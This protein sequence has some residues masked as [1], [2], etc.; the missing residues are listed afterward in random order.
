M[1]ILF[2][3]LGNICR[4]PAGEGVME[5]LVTKAGLGHKFEVDSAG[6]GGWH[7]GEYADSRMSAAAK[8]RGI[9]LKSIGR[10][11]KKD[12]FYH[13][14]YIVTMDEDNYQTCLA[15]QPADGSAILAPMKTYVHSESISGIPDPYYGGDQ[16]FERVLDLLEEGCKNLLKSILEEKQGGER[17]P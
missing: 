9:H 8:R 1:K 15:R 6:T 5:H 14:D 16:G 13:F 4:S 11:I 12:D 7:V 10:Q 3:C 2:V 17:K